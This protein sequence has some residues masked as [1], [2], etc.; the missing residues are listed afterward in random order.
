MVCQQER[1]PDLLIF[2]Q[3][4]GE[5]FLAGI[6]SALP[7]HYDASAEANWV[8]FLSHSSLIPTVLPTA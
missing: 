3:K 7:A 2:N 4:L 1:V 6:P 5:L 8:Y